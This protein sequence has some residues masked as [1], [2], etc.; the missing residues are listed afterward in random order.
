MNRRADQPANL[1]FRDS[2]TAR[3]L[4]GSGLGTEKGSI[5]IFALQVALDHPGVRII[6]HLPYDDATAPFT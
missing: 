1:T 4:S 6:V 3:L 2:V 5:A